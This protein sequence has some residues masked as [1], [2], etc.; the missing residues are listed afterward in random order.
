MKVLIGLF[1][2]QIIN[3]KDIKRTVMTRY[4][5]GVKVL[6]HDSQT[7]I[8]QEFGMKWVFESS[9]VLVYDPSGSGK[10]WVALARLLL[11]PGRAFNALAI[12]CPE[13]VIG[14]FHDTFRTLLWYVTGQVYCFSRIVHLE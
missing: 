14:S 8:A 12:V 9:H 5:S 6:S 3:A 11:E 4:I 13:R 10:L 2:F 1:I 7:S